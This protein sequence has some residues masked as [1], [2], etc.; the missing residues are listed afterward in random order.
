MN[1]LKLALSVTIIAALLISTCGCTSSPTPSTSPESAV[2]P[3]VS[4]ILTTG[5]EFPCINA[6]PNRTTVGIVTK[7]VDGDTIHVTINDTDYTVR[8]IGIDTPENTTKGE[9]MSK[10]ATERDKE[11]V[12]GKKVVLVKDVS[13]TDRYDRLL[14][15]VFVDNIFVNY[16]LVREG[17]AKATPYPPDIS[18]K[19]IFYDAQLLAQQEHRGLWIVRSAS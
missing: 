13:E 9:P 8:Y 4:P 1:C 6:T 10:E 19:Q 17:Y 12:A 14:R 18:C 15:Y 7:V 2:E 11:L 5:I 3:L 16:E